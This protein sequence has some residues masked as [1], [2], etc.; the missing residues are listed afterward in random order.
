MTGD[1]AV[2]KLLLLRGITS[3]NLGQIEVCETVQYIKNV[4]L[5]YEK[6]LLIMCLCQNACLHDRG[7]NR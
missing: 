7:I 5:L 3:A 1:A 6:D 2:V 4:K